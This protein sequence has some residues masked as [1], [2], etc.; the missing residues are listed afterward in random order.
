MSA[1]ELRG[2]DAYDLL[3]DPPFHDVKII[4][5]TSPGGVY[6]GLSEHS[7]SSK[8]ELLALV[9]AA[10]ALRTTRSTIKND[11]SSR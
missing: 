11:T 5:T 10:G 7:V 1:F 4:G 6:P 8:E 2:S 9:H 3:S